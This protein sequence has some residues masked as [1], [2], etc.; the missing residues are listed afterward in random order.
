VYGSETW[1]TAE[2]DMKIL[3]TWK[4][5]I[6]RWIYGPVVQ[7]GLWRIRTDQQLGKLHKYLDTGAYIKKKRLELNGQVLKWIREGHLRKYLTVNQT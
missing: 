1:T 5:K 4:R 2:T 3:S 7:Q 6:L